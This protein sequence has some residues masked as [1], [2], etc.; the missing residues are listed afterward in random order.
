M[1]F[2]LPTN[3]LVVL[4][5]VG[6]LVAVAA[7]VA[8]ALPGVLP[9]GAPAQSAEAPADSATFVPA[10]APEP[11]RYGEDEEWEEHEWE[12]HEGREHEQRARDGDYDE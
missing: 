12:E 10:Y 7:S 11:P 9:V 1:K 5:L 4:S 3:K 8:V 6:G 2:P